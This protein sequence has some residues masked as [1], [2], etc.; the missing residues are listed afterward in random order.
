M[1][2]IFTKNTIVRTLLLVG[3]TV[4]ISLFMPESKEFVYDYSCGKPWTYSLLTAPF[5]IP[6]EL[7]SASVAHKKDSIDSNFKN[8]YRLNEEVAERQ[9]AAF[10]LHVDTVCSTQAERNWAYAKLKEVYEDGVVDNDC[11]QKLQA[12]NNSGLKVVS[13]NVVETVTGENFRSI[14]VA[15]EYLNSGF[16]RLMKLLPSRIKY[17]DYLEPNYVVDTR[18]SQR[19]RNSAYQ[20]VLAPIG[21]LQKGE[22]I[23][24]RG[25]IVNTQTYTILKTYER[26]VA[27]RKDSSAS[28]HYPLIGKIIMILIIFSSVYFYLSMFRWRFFGDMRKMIFLVALMTSFVIL[29]LVFSRH[30]NEGFYIVPFAMIPIILTIF[31]DSRTALY[32]HL[33]EIILCT[34][35]M[36]L[37]VEF[38]FLQFIAGIVTITSLKEMSSRAQLM[39]TAFL[40]FVFY[41]ILFFVY[42]VVKL[43][44]IDTINW[45]CF[46]YFAINTILLGFSYILVYIIEKLFGFISTVTLIELSD[47]N[48]P[49]LREL[50]EECPGTFQHS[51]QVSN[52]AAEA[53]RKINA[54]VQLVRTG[55]L[56]HDIGKM[57][58]PAFF[59]E[60]QHGVNPHEN[61]TPEQSAQ[62]VINHVKGGMK[63]AEKAKLPDVIK[64]FIC[65]HHGLG[66]AKYFYTTACNDV[67]VENVDVEKFRYPGPNPQTKETAVLMMADAVEA[68]SRSIKEYT[69]ENIRNLVTRIV[70]SQISDGLFKDCPLSF[71][72][73]E[74]VKEVFISRLKTI[75]HTRVS[76]PEMKK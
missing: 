60:N 37:P 3:A 12:K 5:D 56:Y 72:D 50:S 19:L 39:R 14:K 10:K 1:G 40:I 49:L 45:T 8:I 33:N 36:S 27:E 71:K 66:T 25:D 75:Y 57:E 26:M 48:N 53:A 30:V 47:V 42:E 62:I 32:V 51:L 23:I 61:I 59:T 63:R 24:D 34:V 7:D 65:Q 11:Y 28:R 35:I 73:V 68:A 64:N 18:L 54:N 70:N 46:A 58:N 76:Y 31:F 52:L 44:R 43:G 15:Y 22:R 17:S 13:D 74:E 55:A 69:E 21:L 6:V 4:L 38:V 16:G 41:S 9:L 20:K 2:K 67:G 29:A